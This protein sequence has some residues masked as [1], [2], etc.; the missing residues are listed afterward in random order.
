MKEY[1]TTDH[2]DLK[3][4]QT[5]NYISSWTF[6]LKDYLE[7]C[8]STRQ[9]VNDLVKEQY[10]NLYPYTKQEEQ[11][12]TTKDILDKLNKKNPNENWVSPFSKDSLP[13]FPVAY[14]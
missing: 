13:K 12:K 6:P 7:L 5:L 11:D 4:Y 10:P 8:P 1:K 14:K 2:I 3:A 9:A